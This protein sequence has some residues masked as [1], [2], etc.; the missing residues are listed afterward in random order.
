LRR[1]KKVITLPN[2][3]KLRGRELCSDAIRR[4]S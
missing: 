2:T 3:A 1:A 4:A